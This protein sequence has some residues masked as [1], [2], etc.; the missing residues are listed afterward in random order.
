MNTSVLETL[1]PAGFPPQSR[2]WIYQSGRPLSPEETAGANEQL[3]QFYEQWTAHGAPVKGWAKVLFGQFVVVIADETATGV[4]GCSTDGMVQI[5]K[6]FER[7]FSTTFFDRLTLTF[8]V[9]D[10][11]QMLPISQ[12]GYALDHGHLSPDT[13]LFNNAVTTLQE[14]QSDW[15]QPLKKSWLG[16]KLGIS[17]A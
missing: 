16:K 11:A 15:M 13:V 4:S 10:K 1:L 3:V 14:L 12:V 8:L 6:S 17:A 5:V 2:V 9:D 7:Q